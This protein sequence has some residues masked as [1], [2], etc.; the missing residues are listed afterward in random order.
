MEQWPRYLRGTWLEVSAAWARLHCLVA[1]VLYLFL[2][3]FLGY[4]VGSWVDS[5]SPFDKLGPLVYFILFFSIYRNSIHNETTWYFCL[6]KKKQ[7]NN[8]IYTTATLHQRDPSLN[9]LPWKK[10]GKHTCILDGTKWILQG[11]GLQPVWFVDPPITWRLC[12]WLHFSLF[13]LL[14]QNGSTD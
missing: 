9:I 2:D 3:F 13:W 12:W 6:P 1:L 8:T 11:D 5:W 10:D 7:K 4:L 14:R